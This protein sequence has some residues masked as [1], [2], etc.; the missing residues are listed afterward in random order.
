MPENERRGAS[1][2][3]TSVPATLHAP[4]GCV[5]A[6]TRNVS[7]TGARLRVRCLAL[8]F[9]PTLDLT[10]TAHAVRDQLPTTVE[11]CLRQRVPGRDVVRRATVVRIGLPLEAPDSCDLGVRFD[12]PLGEE[13]ATWLGI[14]LPALRRGLAAGDAMPAAD[15]AAATTAGARP[16]YR[17]FLTSGAADA[18]P[19]LPCHGDKV[20]RKA[21]RVRMPREGYEHDSAADAITRFARRF[22]TCMTLKLVDVGAHVWTGPVRLCALDLPHERPLDMLLTFAFERRLRA[23][24]LQRLDLDRAAA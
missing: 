14:P 1:R 8:G 5:Q 19:S 13:D 16:M 24:E 15:H 12:R 6:A 11:V 3:A 7:R 2:L 23:A 20:S 10:T 9:A 18:P 21:V 4:S 22:G 17:A